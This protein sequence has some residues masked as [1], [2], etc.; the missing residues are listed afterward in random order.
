MPVGSMTFLDLADLVLQNSKSPMTPDE[1]WNEAVKSGITQLYLE[2][3][4]L[5]KRLKLI[6]G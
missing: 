3:G 4:F 5:S 2:R 6:L 1:I